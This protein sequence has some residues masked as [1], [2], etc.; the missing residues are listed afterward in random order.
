MERE[1]VSLKIAVGMWM[2]ELKGVEEITDIN[3]NIGISKSHYNRYVA[4][5]RKNVDNAFSTMIIDPTDSFDKIN[6]DVGLQK[7]ANRWVVDKEKFLKALNEKR[8]IHKTGDVEEY[9]M[10][11]LATLG[12]EE[13]I[14][15][16]DVD[17]PNR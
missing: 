10:H 14:N 7:K 6:F 13:N 4:R 17:I 1:T 2:M 5:A 15:L 3:P 16:N 9:F 11:I 12:V 8:E